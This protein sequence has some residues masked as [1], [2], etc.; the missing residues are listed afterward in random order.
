M[1]YQEAIRLGKLHQQLGIP[2]E[3]RVCLNILPKGQVGAFIWD[4]ESGN[5]YTVI[6]GAPPIKAQMHVPEHVKN[7][8][9]AT[10][11]D[12]K[13]YWRS[14]IGWDEERETAF[15]ELAFRGIGTLG[16]EGIE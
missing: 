9:K 11:E 10:D 14:T 8:I 5:T 16:I 13:K 4:L 12:L 3:A 15:S 1:Q 7:M 2:A 6:H